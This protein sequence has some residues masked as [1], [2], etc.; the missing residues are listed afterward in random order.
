[1]IAT[2]TLR[3]PRTLGPR[4]LTCSTPSY[5]LRGEGRAQDPSGLRGDV[6]CEPRGVHAG[7]RRVLSVLLV[8]A[9][10]PWVAS[11]MGAR[12]AVSV[13]WPCATSQAWW[14][15]ASCMASN[16]ALVGHWALRDG[17]MGPNCTSAGR[18]GCEHGRR[19]EGRAHCVAA[20]WAS[21]PDGAGR[22]A[23]TRWRGLEAGGG[24][25]CASFAILASN[26]S[27]PDGQ[28]ALS[29]SRHHPV[30]EL[31]ME[32]QDG[33]LVQVERWVTRTVRCT[34]PMYVWLLVLG[35]DADLVPSPSE[36]SRGR[37][38]LAG[39]GSLGLKWPWVLC[40]LVVHGH[41]GSVRLGL[42]LAWGLML[43]W[44]HCLVVAG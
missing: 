7:S 33:N 1:V 27:S 20:S 2:T 42:H 28:I 22:L 31:C 29:R 38:G 3:A 39:E 16:Y 12:S 25:E 13:G 6:S 9:S 30:L 19:T 18:V 10:M 17:V 44:V 35:Q 32:G 4:C 36:I 26:T 23:W 37:I 11:C 40:S 43:A 21:P 8:V 41:A 15:C 14:H 5:V 24:A 34:Q